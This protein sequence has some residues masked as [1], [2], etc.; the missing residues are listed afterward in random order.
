MSWWPFRKKTEE[1]PERNGAPSD[2]GSPSLGEDQALP[3]TPSDASASAREEGDGGALSLLARGLKKTAAGLKQILGLRRAI[4]EAFLADLEVKMYEADFGPDTVTA[5]LAA[6]RAAWKAETL[7]ESDQIAPFLQES[8]RAQLADKDTQLA[9]APSGPTVVL[10]C[11]VNGTG[12]TTSIAKLSHWLAARGDKVILAAGDTFR[13]AATEQ[14][15]VWS[16]RIGLPLVTGGAG[17]DPASVAY[18]AC[19]RAIAEQ[20]DYLVVDTAGRLHTQANL[21]RELEKIRRVIAGRIP[22]APHETLL[23]LDATTGQNAVNQA[24][25]FNRAVA[26]TGLIMAKLDGTAKGGILVTLHNRFRI[27][28]KFVGLGEKVADIAEFS[29]EKYVQALFT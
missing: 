18:S 4:D 8:L 26:L 7:R 14:L 25:A 5:L 27:P 3:E 19:E 29:T 6:V 15:Q 2:G 20:A 10:V 16:Q 24:D 13:A 17:S 28:V 22:G 1:S 9:R 12:K 23:V 11:G 21:M